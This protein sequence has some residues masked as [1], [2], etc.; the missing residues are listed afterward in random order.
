VNNR[1]QDIADELGVELDEEQI[2]DNP[3]AVKRAVDQIPQDSGDR[4]RQFWSKEQ[5]T[6]LCSYADKQARESLDNE[7]KAEQVTSFRNRAL[8]YVL[9]L[10]GVRSGEVLKDPNDSQRNGVTWKDT[11]LENGTVKV[12]GKTRSY[13]YAQLPAESTEALKQFKQVLNPESP[14]WPVF[15]SNHAPSKYRTFREQSGSEPPEEKGIDSAIR[16]HG[17]TPP[18]LS[19]NGARNILEKMCEEAGITNNGEPLKLH[20]ARRGLGHELYRKGHAEL[21]QTALRHSSIEVTH[22]AYSDIKASETA[23]RV[24]DVLDN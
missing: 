11:D 24:D 18:A 23:D 2:S 14:N 17:V 20:G 6:Q 22:Q 5:R 15:P 10:S 1:L 16:E 21:A 4:D 8:I 19:K 13:E 9:S 3:A 7:T 12:L